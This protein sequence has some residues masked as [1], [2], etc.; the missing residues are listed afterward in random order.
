MMLAR[1]TEDISPSVTLA[2]SSK[3]KEMK[4]RG[5]DVIIL[6]AGEPDFD[7]PIAIKQSAIDAINSGFTKYTPASGIKELKEAII[8]KFR[9][10]NGLEYSLD[11]IIVSCGAKHSLYN[12]LLSICDPLDEVVIFS[13][14]WVSYPEMIRLVGAKP[15]FVETKE[16]D[17]FIPSD[18]KIKKVIT[19]QTK[20]IIVNSP[21][22]PTGSIYGQDILENI[23]KIAVENDL[24]IIS[25]E[26]Y[27]KIIYDS[28]SH[29]SIATL[30]E[31]IKKRTIVVN[32]VSKTYAMTGWR[33]GYVAADRNIVKAMSDIQSH[34]TSNPASISQKAAVKA[35]NDCKDDVTV[36]VGEFEKRRN[37]VVDRLKSVKGLSFSFPKG[38]F[39][40]FL[41]VR[42]FL[43]KYYDGVKIDSALDLAGYL[44]EK[45]KVA[46]VPGEG[47]GVKGYIRLSFASSI[48]E[49]DKGLTRIKHALE[50]IGGMQDER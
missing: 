40:I 6:G 19:S 35:L 32:A 4:K 12:T 50:K 34:T 26:V 37:F 15:V 24:W 20:A 17:S 49:L 8:E 10:D 18:E 3:A 13:P 2:I 45:F 5:E 41:N 44:L 7:T 30:G 42:N 33:I 23:G 28:L 22:N 1:R 29:I 38:T 31:E 36:M 14:Y 21:C 47:F 39:Y 27:E 9:R 43:N 16:E 11:E 48:E 25:D 46:V